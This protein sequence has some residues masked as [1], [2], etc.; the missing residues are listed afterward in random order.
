MSDL[1][2]AIGDLTQAIRT[3]GIVLAVAALGTPVI[4]LIVVLVAY[5]RA[6]ARGYPT[7]ALTEII[8]SAL[9]PHGTKRREHKPT[10]DPHSRR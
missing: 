5:E 3:P 4:R 1:A 2:P 7:D 10:D 9:G 6:A 8:R